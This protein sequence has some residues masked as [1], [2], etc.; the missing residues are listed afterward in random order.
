MVI[1]LGICALAID[2]VAAYLGRVQCQRAADAAALAGASQFVNGGCTS[3][4]GCSAGG[5]QETPAPTQA[6]A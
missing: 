2:L 3:T 5:S 6:G 1:L 4:G